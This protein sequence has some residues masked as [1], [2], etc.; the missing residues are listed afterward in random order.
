MPKL[1]IT[2][3]S[4]MPRHQFDA[5]IQSGSTS[6]KSHSC[7]LCM[8]LAMTQY[9]LHVSSETESVIEKQ[10][11]LKAIGNISPFRNLVD[12]P[13][14]YKRE[15]VFRPN[16]VEEGLS[17]PVAGLHLSYLHALRDTN[18]RGYINQDAMK[19]RQPRVS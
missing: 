4:W 1:G 17:D 12:V 10:V 15:C 6:I 16:T 2:L 19:F 8:R 13:G 3:M 5:L 9:L 14:G 18:G 7:L 11:D